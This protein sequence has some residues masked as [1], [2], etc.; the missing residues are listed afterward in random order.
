M[1]RRPEPLR[2]DRI[3]GFGRIMADTRNFIRDNFV[4]FFKTILFLVGPI[5]LLTCTLQTF[6]EVNMADPLQNDQS[7]KFGSYIAMTMIFS[8]LRWAINGFV[9]AVVVS[10]FIKVYREKG[11][12]KFDVNDVSKSILRD[13]LGNLLAIILL[14]AGVAIIA[15]LIGYMIYGLAET[16]MDAAFLFLL[17]GWIGYF[18]IRFPFWYFIFSVFFSRTSGKKTINVFAAMG[19]AGRVFAGNWWMTWVIFFCMWLL[20][21]VIGTL[22]SLPAELA[23]SFIQLFAYDIDQ[24]STDWHLIQTILVSIG[25]FAKTIINSV[26][27]VSVALQFYSLKEKLYGEGTME[28]INTIGT[29]KDD[30]DVELIY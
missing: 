18:L 7:N 9:I 14:F 10:H 5:A 27:C 16:S 23:G 24:N 6:Y 25:E 3:R 22:V 19:L 20:L 15:L 21:F 1:N 17:G 11:P 26:F 8:Q 4:V 12:G 30:D 29:Q 13:I 2:F 28:I